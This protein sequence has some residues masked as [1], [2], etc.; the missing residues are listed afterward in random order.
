MHKSKHVK[1]QDTGIIAV[2]GDEVTERN[3]E[4]QI[5]VYNRHLNYVRHISN[6]NKSEITAP[7]F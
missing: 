3:N 7:Q 6:R 1:G 4:G 2:V 5:I